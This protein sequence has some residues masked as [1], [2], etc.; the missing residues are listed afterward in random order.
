M[1]SI[2]WRQTV[3]LT[4]RLSFVSARAG[5]DTEGAQLPRQYCDAGRL[6]SSAD[7]RSSCRLCLSQLVEQVSSSQRVA[8]PGCFSAIGADPRL[9]PFVTIHKGELFCTG[10]MKQPYADTCTCRASTMC[11]RRP[12]PVGGELHCADHKLCCPII[13][14][15]SSMNV[16]EDRL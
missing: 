12:L 15:M 6:P 3:G 16:N 5:Q 8:P 13:F 10:T 9:P 4:I 7:V 11:L 2:R 14:A 1:S